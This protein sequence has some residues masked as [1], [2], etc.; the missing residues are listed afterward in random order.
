MA[1]FVPFRALRFESEHLGAR[2]A[3]P[4][5]V[6]SE[7]QVRELRA[8]GDVEITRVDVP[9]VDGGD[10]PYALAADLLADWIDAHELS[11]DEKPSFT[12]CRMSFI[13]ALGHQRRIDGVIGALEVVDEGGGR[14]L[15]HERTTPKASTDRLDLT[16][17]TR[18][19]LSPVWGLSLGQ[20]LTSLLAE[21][22]DLVGEV[23]W[24]GVVHRFERVAN[25]DRV[26]AITECLRGSDVLIADGH[27]RYGI[28]RHFRDEVRTTTGRNDTDA[29]YT[30]AFVNELVEDQLAIAAIHRLYRTDDADALVSS[31]LRSY[32][33]VDIC[34]VGEHTLDDMNRLGCVCLVRRDGSG[35]MLRPRVDAFAGVRD[36]DGLR[37]EAAI[38][39]AQYRVEYQHGVDEVL[40][41]LSEG[42]A[43]LAVLIRPVGIDEIRATGEQG[44]LMPPKST[45]F[46]PKLLTGP[47]L[48]PLSDL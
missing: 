23:H 44:E 10:D 15:P 28:A 12:I 14:V 4:Y 32:E 20:G 24:D 27:H 43:D 18:A 37:L 47:V 30:M 34:A 22:G 35:T 9:L 25:D 31:L 8:R 7:A 41:A 48:R 36:L 29:E 39:E 21:P 2:V 40:H 19:N 6:L 13:D 26:A 1:E 5:D 42:R 33:E 3:P 38:H 17:S 45:F 46:T 16:R 11:L